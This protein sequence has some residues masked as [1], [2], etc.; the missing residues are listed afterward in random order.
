MDQAEGVP[1]EPKVARVTTQKVITNAGNNFH[2]FIPDIISYE[3]GSMQGLNRYR[4][5]R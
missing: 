4:C 3:D 2:I 5:N 1:S